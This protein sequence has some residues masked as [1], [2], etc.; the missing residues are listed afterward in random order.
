MD[1]DKFFESDSQGSSDDGSVSDNESTG[2]TQAGF[3]GY[4][5]DGKHMGSLTRF[6]NHSCE[7]NLSIYTVSYNHS[8]QNLYDLAFFALDEIRA[9]T[10][11][12]FDYKDEN[13]R[14]VITE[15]KVD[16]IERERGYRPAKCRC[17]VRTC[18]GYFFT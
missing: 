4:V 6:I 16:R 7:P 15:E 14:T 2:Q 18:R 12:T 8:D 5:C 3:E 1:Y 10:E 17:G 13:D 9:G 11:L